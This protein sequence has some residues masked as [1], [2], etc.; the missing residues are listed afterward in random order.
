MCLE[1]SGSS[2]GNS[3]FHRQRNIR[4]YY[5]ADWSLRQIKSSNFPTSNCAKQTSSPY[6]YLHL[7]N[8]EMQLTANTQSCYLAVN[9]KDP[10][11]IS[12]PEH[13]GQLMWSVLGCS[14]VLRQPASTE[15][16]AWPLQGLCAVESCIMVAQSSLRHRSDGLYLSDCRNRIN[17]KGYEPDLASISISILEQQTLNSTFNLHWLPLPRRAVASGCSIYGWCIQPPLASNERFS[18]D[19]C[20]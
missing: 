1:Y 16:A 14:D 13:K 12:A 10:G 5:L 8:P 4:R 17:N 20:D 15:R 9:L 11:G 3:H 6:V 18:T 2:L 7:S 19:D